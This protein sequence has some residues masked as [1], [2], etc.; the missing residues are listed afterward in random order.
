MTYRL[1]IPGALP[2]L[3]EYIRAE[4]TNR[5]IAAKLKKE[6]QKVISGYITQQL[7]GVHIYEPVFMAYT[8]VERDRKRDKDNIS[9][10]KKFIQ[11]ALVGARVLKNDGWAEIAGFSDSFKVDKGHPCVVVD[12]EEFANDSREQ[13]VC[14]AVRIRTVV[15]GRW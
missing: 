12:I 10:A 2:G 14:G 5:H 3:N 1:V 4:R 9:F 8:W 6:T 15:G 11:D 7:R 13:E